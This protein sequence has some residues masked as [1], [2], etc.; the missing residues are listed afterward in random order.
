[1]TDDGW[2]PIVGSSKQNNYRDEITQYRNP[3]K[4][5]ETLEAETTSPHKKNNQQPS[6]QISPPQTQQP[7]RLN[8]AT[9]KIALKTQLKSNNTILIRS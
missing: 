3:I 5:S 1:M 4:T 6:S 8:K 7:P 2:K 9:T